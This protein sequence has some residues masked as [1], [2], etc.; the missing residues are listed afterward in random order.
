M[1]IKI[2]P[3]KIVV[4]QP[5]SR[6]GAPALAYNQS[7]SFQCLLPFDDYIKGKLKDRP[8]AY[9]KATITGRKP[10]QKVTIGE[11]VQGF[12]F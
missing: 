9:F 2:E 12:T 5:G 4:P 7:S 1:R 10:K 11:E 8:F 6:V 3:V